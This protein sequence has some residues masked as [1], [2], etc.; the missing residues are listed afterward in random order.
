MLKPQPARRDAA[1]DAGLPRAK[2]GTVEETIDMSDVVGPATQGVAP[3]ELAD[4]MRATRGG[5]TYANVHGTMS[6]GGEIRGQIRSGGG[7]GRDDD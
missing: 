4:L 2:S 1:G 7:H 5:L 6:P 3:G